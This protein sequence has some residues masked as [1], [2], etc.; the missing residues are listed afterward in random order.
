MTQYIIYIPLFFVYVLLGTF[1][2]HTYLTIANNKSL[3]EVFLENTD[4]TFIPFFVLLFPL[5]FSIILVY[6]ILKFIVGGTVRALHSNFKNK[7]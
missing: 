1:L 4:S 6:H 3:K 7:K 5:F 2:V